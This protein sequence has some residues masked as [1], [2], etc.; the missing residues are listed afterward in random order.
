MK[1]I[2]NCIGISL[3]VV[4]FLARCGSDRIT[5]TQSDSPN[6]AMRGN[7]YQEDLVSKSQIK[8]KNA[9][10]DLYK[11]ELDIDSSGYVWEVVKTIQSDT[12]GFFRLDSIESGSYSILITSGDKKGFSGYIEYTEKGPTLELDSLFVSSTQNISGTI[13]DSSGNIDSNLVLGLIGTP[14]SDTVTNTGSFVFNNIPIGDFI[15]DI[16]KFTTKIESVFINTGI[17]PDSLLFDSLQITFQGSRNQVISISTFDFSPSLDTSYVIAYSDSSSI[18]I[19][20]INEDQI[21]TVTVQNS[22]IKIVS[23]NYTIEYTV[24]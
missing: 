12:S 7:I 22:T 17:S 21:D 1:N 18:G 10:I 2:M 16:T 11:I 19:N 14:Y 5:G 6:A 8:V 3:Y 4:L 23:D 9:T 24:Q 20:V 13:K 15:M